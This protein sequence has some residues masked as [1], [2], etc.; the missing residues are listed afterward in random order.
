[1]STEE[2]KTSEFVDSENGPSEIRNKEELHNV[3]QA[4]IFASPEILN[5]KK[6]KEIIGDF[7]TEPIMR[8]ALIEINDS[9]NQ[10]SSPFELVE[11]VKGYRFRTRKNYLPWIKKMIAPEQ[12]SRRLSQAALETLAIIAYKQPITKSEIENVRGVSCDGPV[13]NL[14][15]KKLITLGPR[16]EN[17]GHAFQYI[18]TKEFLKAF[19]LNR[20]PEDLPRLLELDSLV[21]A[22]DLL[23]QIIEGEWVEDEQEEY[24]DTDQIE[25]SVGDD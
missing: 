13:K 5:L 22:N 20:I 12:Y 7:L 17:V 8:D 15:D 10:I 16:S 25:L 11:Q 23:P 21:G 3:L 4:L 14:L 6:L 24:D 1:M 19:G 18:T 9:L 2:N